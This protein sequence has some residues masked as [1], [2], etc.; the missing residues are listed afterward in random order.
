MNIAIIGAGTIGSAIAQI[1]ARSGHAVALYD[2]SQ[3]VLQRAIIQITKALELNV[4]KGEISYEQAAR[5]R[6]LIGTTVVLEHAG[7]ADFILEAAPEDLDTKKGIFERLDKAAPRTTTLA[8]TT[9]SLSISVIASAAKQFPDRVVGL[10][11]FN[12]PAQ[13]RLVEVIRGDQ[14]S[15]TAIDKAS[16]FAQSLGKETVTIKD[17]PGF[18]VN[19]VGDAFTGEALRMVGEGNLDAETVDRLMESLDF[20][21]PPFRH[22]DNVGLDTALNFKEWLYDATYQEPRFRPSHILRHLVQANRLGR[23]TKQ[24]FYKYTDE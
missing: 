3:Q 13:V 4:Q 16:Q 17:M 19:R 14:T 18:L 1:A 24:G 9:N 7:E 12:P 2:I 22:L 10:H 21:T 11:F 8:S 15:P 5:T 20:K 23:K 6:A